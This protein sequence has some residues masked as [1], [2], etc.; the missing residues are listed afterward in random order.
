[1]TGYF[2]H[3]YCNVT[4]E[5]C[6]YIIVGYWSCPS[7]SIPAVLLIAVQK[8]DLFVSEVGVILFQ[9]LENLTKLMNEI[10]VLRLRVDLHLL[11]VRQ[12]IL[13]NTV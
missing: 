13:E 4:I 10:R 2:T 11:L 6:I 3:Y 12:D 8:L 7:S 5:L 1:M 9:S